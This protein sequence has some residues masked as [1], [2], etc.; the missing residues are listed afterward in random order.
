MV[1]P[2]RTLT[3][4]PQRGSYQRH[5]NAVLIMTQFR[6]RFTLNGHQPGTSTKPLC[7]KYI[8]TY[9][10]PGKSR[11]LLTLVPDSRLSPTRPVQAR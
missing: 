7:H 8:N 3:D 6:V 1:P 11:A 5:L 4:R 9:I 2:S 10:Y